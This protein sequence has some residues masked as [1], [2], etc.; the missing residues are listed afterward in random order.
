MRGFPGV[1]LVAAGEDNAFAA[2][3]PRG[4]LPTQPSVPCGAGPPWGFML[5]WRGASALLMS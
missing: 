4:H 3:L 5:G 1:W 2:W